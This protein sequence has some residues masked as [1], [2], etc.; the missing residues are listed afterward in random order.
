MLSQLGVAVH[1]PLRLILIARLLDYHQNWIIV[2]RMDVVSH[3]I[4][5][6]L[7]AGR[8]IV[9]AKDIT[10]LFYHGKAV[11]LTLWYWLND[12]K[13]I[14]WCKFNYINNHLWLVKNNNHLKTIYIPNCAIFSPNVHVCQQC[15]LVVVKDSN[16]SHYLNAWAYLVMIILAIIWCTPNMTV[17]HKW[18]QIC[19]LVSPN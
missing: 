14:V 13:W 1:L 15:T 17:P 18:T 2:W 6:Y 4:W 3:L 5:N 11:I 10:V 16:I 8:A 7:M 12:G 9:V 19:W